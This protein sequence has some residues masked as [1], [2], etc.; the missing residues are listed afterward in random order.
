[1]LMGLVRI[2]VR[3]KIQGTRFFLGGCITIINLTNFVFWNTKKIEL[4]QNGRSVEL[5]NNPRR[6]YSYE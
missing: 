3:N 4:E 1:M 5:T 2:G 6:F